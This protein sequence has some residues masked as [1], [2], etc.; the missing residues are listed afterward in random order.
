MINVTIRAWRKDLED[1]EVDN[2]VIDLQGRLNRLYY[3][4]RD[5]LA[6][7]WF[8]ELYRR[9]ETGLIVELDTESMDDLENIMADI[10]RFGWQV[11]GIKAD[12]AE[13]RDA[14]GA[15]YRGS[16]PQRKIEAGS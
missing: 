10:R 5:T 8:N 7:R 6:A 2:A 11:S 12:T 4:L 3:G 13:R 16:V 15:E 9:I 1:D 14:N